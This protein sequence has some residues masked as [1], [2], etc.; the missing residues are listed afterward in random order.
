MLVS[1]LKAKYLPKS[2]TCVLKIVCVLVPKLQA[3]MHHVILLRGPFSRS[4]QVNIND[5]FAGSLFRVLFPPESKVNWLL[6][7]EELLFKV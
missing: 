2:G 7:L 4:A 3:P 1:K 5:D 6:K